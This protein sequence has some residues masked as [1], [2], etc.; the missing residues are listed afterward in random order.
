MPILWRIPEIPSIV[1][2]I[3]TLAAFATSGEIFSKRHETCVGIE[4]ELSGWT[5]TSNQRRIPANERT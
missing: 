5:W 3:G 1:E 4:E 2:T